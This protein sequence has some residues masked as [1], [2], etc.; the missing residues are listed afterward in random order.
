MTG[1]TP[2]ALF[3]R[4][5]FAGAGGCQNCQ[6][7]ATCR[8]EVDDNLLYPPNDLDSVPLESQ[9]HRRQVIPARWPVQLLTFSAVVT[10][11]SVESY[12]ASEA[13]RGDAV[14]PSQK[15]ESASKGH[16]SC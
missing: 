8:D 4:A 3:S 6:V 14:K 16:G 12:A 1:A 7:A 9:Q 10:Y 5:F 15:L 2:T 11:G 13:G